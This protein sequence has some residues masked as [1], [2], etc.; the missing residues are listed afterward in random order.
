MNIL[1]LGVI[2]AFCVSL[3]TLATPGVPAGPVS[4]SSVRLASQVD[5]FAVCALF[6]MAMHGGFGPIAVATGGQGR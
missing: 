2:C 1:R 6:H 4:S 5:A 3:T